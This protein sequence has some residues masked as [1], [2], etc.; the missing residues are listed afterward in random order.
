MPIG[1]VRVKQPVIYPRNTQNPKVD[2]TNYIFQSYPLKNQGTLE[3][4]DGNT[5]R[6]QDP[7]AYSVPVRDIHSGYQGIR[8]R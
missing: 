4:T 7:K 8:S 5:S 1:Y 6:R 2:P 3:A